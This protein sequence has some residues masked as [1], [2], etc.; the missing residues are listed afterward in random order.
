MVCFYFFPV[1]LSPSLSITY[2]N[3]RSFGCTVLELLTGSPPY[4]ELRKEQAICKILESESPP[5]YPSNLSKELVQFLNCCFQKEPSKRSSVKQLLNHPWI[6][7]NL[8]FSLHT[9]SPARSV[10]NEPSCHSKDFHSSDDFL[11]TDH[12]PPYILPPA[13]FFSSEPSLPS[14]FKSH[15]HSLAPSD[16]VESIFEILKNYNIKSKISFDT[17]RRIFSLFLVFP[18]FCV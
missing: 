13:P 16:H 5:D 9:I 12:E 2:S 3:N 10:S 1:L 8:S 11:S 7:T 6:L 14:S 17:E 18:K 4:K 15:Q